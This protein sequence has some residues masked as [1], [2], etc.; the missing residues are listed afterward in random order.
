VKV[1]VTGGAGRVGTL[2]VRWLIDRGYQV[3][4]I[5]RRPGVVFEGCTYNQCDITDPNALRQVMAGIE[6]IVHMAAIPNPW[7][8]SAEELFRINCQGTFNVYNAAAAAGITKVV[9]ASSI[10]ALGSAFG[11]RDFVPDCFPIDESHP[12][13]TTDPYSFSKNVME[14]TAAYFW[15]RGRISSV[16]LRFPAVIDITAGGR[17]WSGTSPEERV[18]AFQELIKT[19]RKEVQ[20]WIDEMVAERAR[21]RS[22]R[23]PDDHHHHKW[24]EMEKSPLDARRMLHF[25]SMG[26]ADF[27]AIIDA[28]DV[29]QAI[30][31]SLHTS[32]E[33]C[34]AIFINDSVNTTGVDSEVLIGLF[35][36]QVKERKRPL[37]NDESIVSIDRARELIG[38]EPRFHAIQLIAHARIPES[39][40]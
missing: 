25:L 7:M 34:H 21:W 30:E 8:V 24:K 14:E 13:H 10:N 37:A 35:F 9:C 40:K 1:L 29:A 39:A 19:P 27:W 32:F 31:K 11:V 28:K 17:H 18:Q 15:R 3:S 5:G 38:F 33:G 4:V 22:G 12:C 23:H 26:K 20:E 36:P 6:A 16:C 2:I